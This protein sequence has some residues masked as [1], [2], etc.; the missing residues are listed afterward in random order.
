M[1]KEEGGAGSGSFSIILNLFLIAAI[2][3]STL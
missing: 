1:G 2:F 3:A